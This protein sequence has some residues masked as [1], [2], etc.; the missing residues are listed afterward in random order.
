MGLRNRQGLTVLAFAHVYLIDML[1]S[2]VLTVEFCVHW[3]K[4]H[5]V[6]VTAAKLARETAATAADISDSASLGQETAVTVLITVFLLL[7]RVYFT[8]VL[9]AYARQLVRSQNLRRYNGSPRGSWKAL[10]Q[11]VLLAPRESFW[12]GFK[13]SSTS[14]TYSPL[15]GAAHHRSM[16]SVSSGTTL[17]N[18]PKFELDDFIDEESSLHGEGMSSPFVAQSIGGSEEG[19]GHD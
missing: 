18:D 10:L 7:V 17:L 12:T 2:L 14:A 5:Q 19:E 11:N 4:T 15:A 6:D 16:N 8:L 1:V 3:F 13:S 9:I